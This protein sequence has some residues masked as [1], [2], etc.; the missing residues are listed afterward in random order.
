MAMPARAD[1]SRVASSLVP[2]RGRPAG[3]EE[4]VERRVG[5]VPRHADQEFDRRVRRDGGHRDDFVDPVTLGLEPEQ[6]QRSRDEDDRIQFD[7]DA[8]Q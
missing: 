8:R 5:I 4:V 7:R 2:K 1:S 3:Q 6:P